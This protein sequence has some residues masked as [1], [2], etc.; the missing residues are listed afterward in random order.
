VTG[1]VWL[2]I[3]IVRE[4]NPDAFFYALMIP[5]FTWYFTYQR[6]DMAKRPFIIHVG[7]LLMHLVGLCV[8]A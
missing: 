5:F 2:L 3:L 4:C 8:G 7:G 6:W 1:Q